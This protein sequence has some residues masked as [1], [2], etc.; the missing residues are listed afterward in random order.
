MSNYTNIPR[1]P[2]YP[3]VS[4]M[5]SPMHFPFPLTSSSS[6]LVWNSMLGAST[7]S[8]F[9]GMHGSL[10]CQQLVRVTAAQD[11]KQPLA[12]WE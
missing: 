9:Q 1:F 3:P 5:R 12:R 6:G 7:V 10:T 4:E 2:R 8:K 11:P